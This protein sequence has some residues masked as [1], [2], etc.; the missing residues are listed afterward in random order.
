MEK[1]TMVWIYTCQVLSFRYFSHERQ[2]FQMI[3]K[4]HM[5]AVHLKCLEKQKFQVVPKTKKPTIIQ[6][7]LIL[8][9][10]CID[11]VEKYIILTLMTTGIG[12][13]AISTLS[14]S[15]NAFFAFWAFWAFFAFFLVMRLVELATLSAGVG[16]RARVRANFFG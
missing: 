14:R 11:N 13:L 15:S 8:H 5:K 6:S 16:E 4:S 9:S 12:V 7:A 1:S 2:Q 10:Q 3:Q